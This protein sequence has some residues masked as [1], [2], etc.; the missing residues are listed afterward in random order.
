MYLS[1]RWSYSALASETLDL[2]VVDGNGAR[3]TG[4]TPTTAQILLG[5]KPQ[6]VGNNLYTIFGG[7]YDIASGTQIGS[8]DEDGNTPAS[9]FVVDEL[10][11][12]IFVWKRGFLRS[13]DLVTLELL[14]IAQIDV[15]PDYM[16]QP[17]MVLWGT[18]GVAL[19]D[20]NRLVVFSGPF[21][22]TY[23]GGSN[24]TD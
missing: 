1:Q 4:S 7:V 2:M 17:T 16:D 5:L 10:H 18:E 12:R 21:F 14:A 19:T 9:G 11:G 23:R 8:F 6:R 22:T 13:H 20:N 3:L 24:P 15:T